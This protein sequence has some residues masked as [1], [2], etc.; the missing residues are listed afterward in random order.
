MGQR[1]QLALVFEEDKSA[2]HFACLSAGAVPARYPL[3]GT[4]PELT[5]PLGFNA[6]LVLLL[7]LVTGT[8]AAHLCE[9]MTINLILEGN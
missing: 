6:N 3:N 9:N 7:L 4:M 2:W 1:D 5:S 8:N